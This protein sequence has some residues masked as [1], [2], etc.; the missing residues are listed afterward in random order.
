MASVLEKKENHEVQL[1]IDVNPEAFE[2]ALQRSFRKNANRFMIPGFRKGKAPMGLV[3]KY[4][5]EG[6]LYEDAIDF[7]ANPAYTEALEEHNLH[8]VSQPAI[9]IIDIGREKGLKFSV[10]VTIKPEVELG[11]YEGV[12][13]VQ[14]VYPV[15][16]EEVDAEIKRTQERNGRMIPVEDRPIQDG[17]T[18]NI[19]YL[20]SLD[21]VPFEG[22]AADSYDLKIGSNTFIPGFEEQLIGHEAGETFDI[23][24]TFPEE[25]QNEE[26]A[27]KKAV[28]NVTVNNVKVR[29]LPVLDDEF[30]KDVSE[31]DTLEEYRGS[32]RKKLEESASNRAKGI[33]EDN[34][35]RAVNANAKVDIPDVMVDQEV[36]RMVDEQ[37]N[38]MRYQ[39]IELDQYLSYLG[40]TLDTFK[41]QLRDSARE[42]VQTR[43]VLEA[44]SEAQAVEATEEEIEEEIG[45][46]AK[47]YQMEA[48][49][50]KKRIP[51]GEDN[52]VAEAIIHRKTVEWL[53]S[54]AVPTAA[55]EPVADDSEEE[56]QAELPAE[57]ETT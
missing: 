38:Q 7:A 28:F 53:V 35:I 3:T 57:P 25:Y 4:Y 2:D 40:Q 6:V 49:E 12:E 26:L 51:E 24:V 18:A 8:P 39:G 27:G 48:D 22:G 5:G 13:A 9:D 14:P 34:V 32:V 10:T 19:N 54:K 44:V 29:E 46:M 42:R 33:F 47:M 15:T 21:D 20:G 36:D 55:P 23:E 50:L 1:T 31:F 11:Q 43:L 52:F 56:K 30:A 17:D 45:K 16:D 37:S 41:E